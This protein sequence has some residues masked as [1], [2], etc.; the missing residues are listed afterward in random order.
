[1]SFLHRIPT[2]IFMVLIAAPAWGQSGHVMNG[3]G[4]VDQGMSGAGMAAPHDVLT[5]LHWNPAGILSEQRQQLDI[6]LQLLMPTAR[7]ASGVDAGA[8]GPMGPGQSLR[9]V[10]DSDAGPFPIPSLG[11]VYNP[12]NK[13]WA[14]GI[15]VFGVGG[16]GVDYELSQANPI[17]S[18]QMPDGGMGFGRMFSE[19]MLMQIAPTIAIEISE[20]I[21]VGV[22]PVLNMAALELSVFPATSPTL[23]GQLPDGT[24]LAKYPDAPSDWAMGFGFQAGVQAHVRQ[25]L[26]V[27][28]SFKSRQRFESFEFKPELAGASDFTF[29]LDYPMIVSGGLAYTHPAGL[30]LAGDVR[31]IDFSNTEGFDKTGFDATAAV[32]GFGWESIVVVAVG[33]EYD[34]NNRLVV[35]TGY[36]WN[37]SPIT[38]ETAFFNAPSPALITQRLSGGFTWEVSDRVSLSSA[39]QYGFEDTVSGSWQSPLVQGQAVPG[40]DV[41]HSLSTFTVVMGL[42]TRW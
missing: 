42:Q 34:L 13:P 10:S 7:I 26:D 25:D 29:D 4:P 2:V 40:T 5:A 14:A 30:R 24:P 33:A 32:Q 3:V 20:Y 28:L 9:G 23:F 21:Q 11:Y 35:R 16:F 6:S 38:S 41:T 19:F 31:W 36:G 18:P 17:L 15:S 22:S 12:A 1:M 37:E 8:F 27:A 39:A